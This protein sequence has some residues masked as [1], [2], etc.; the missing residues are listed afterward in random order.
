VTVIGDVEF[1]CTSRRDW[2]P[3][4]FISLSST[5]EFDI[6]PKSLTRVVVVQWILQERRVSQSRVWFFSRTPHSLVT[7]VGT[8]VLVN[9][10]KSRAFSLTKRIYKTRRNKMKFFQKITQADGVSVD[11]LQGCCRYRQSLNRGHTSRRR[12]D[13]NSRYWIRRRQLVNDDNLFVW[14][15]RTLSHRPR[16]LSSEVHLNPHLTLYTKPIK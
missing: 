8:H 11:G 10:S 4:S 14:I 2:N 12:V 5:I 9:Y 1:F 6:E 13:T 16:L 15:K 3:V 7:S